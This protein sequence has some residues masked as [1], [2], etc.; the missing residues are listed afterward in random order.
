MR[1]AT[2][3]VVSTLHELLCLARL[4]YLKIET[5]SAGYLYT[6]NTGSNHISQFSIDYCATRTKM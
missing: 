1:A 3:M 6:Q 4:P 2:E 5:D